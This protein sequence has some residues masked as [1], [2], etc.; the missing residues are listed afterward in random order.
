M[1]KIVDHD[2]YRAGLALKAAAYFSQHGYAGANMRDLAAALGL[3]K[4]ALYH[5]FPTKKALFEA[6][7]TQVMQQLGGAEGAGEQDKEAA[8]AQLFTAMQ[9]TF[10]AEMALV[11]D[12]LRCKD[13][14]E[15]AA[16]PSMQQAITAYRAKVGAIVPADAVDRT[17][18]LLL[19]H[20]LI[21]YVSGNDPDPQELRLMPD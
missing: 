19:G 6:A 20:L 16:E 1:P 2:A 15:I 21:A 12:F 9:P 11:F 18:A 3:S 4:S 7:T 17:L 8:L 10:G 14:A 13:A 5:Y